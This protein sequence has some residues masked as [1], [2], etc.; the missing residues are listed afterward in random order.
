VVAHIADQPF[1]GSELKRLGVSPGYMRKNEMT[2]RLLGK[3]LSLIYKNPSYREN[4]MR[5]SKLMKNDNAIDTAI[6]A[7]TDLSKKTH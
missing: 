2:S 1:W 3:F 5:I 7:L 4:A 6:Q